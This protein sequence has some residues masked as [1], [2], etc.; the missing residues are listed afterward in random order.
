M[1]TADTQPG[2][3]E[4][5]MMRSEES[6]M[7]SEESM[8]RS[9]ES[10]MRSEESMMRSEESR[11]R[12]GG[13]VGSWESELTSRQRSLKF[14]LALKEEFVCPVCGGVVLNPQQNSC[15]HIYCYHCL[16]GLLESSSPSSPVC[17]VD[18]AVITPA[19]VFQDNCCRREISCL[20][21]YCTNFPACTSVVTLQHLQEHLSSCQYEQLQCT[22]P[23][24]RAA[25]QRRH[26][27]EHLTSTCPHRTEPCPHCQ[28]PIRLNLIQDHL[29]T[30]CLQVEVGCP[31]SCSQKVPRHKLAEHRESC[32]E[33]HVDCSYR[34]FG[35]LVQDKR[36]KV[37]LHEDTA[38]NHHMLLVLRSNTHLEQQV[39]VLQEEALLR[40]QEVQANSLLLTGLQKK[41]Q[42]LLQQSSGHEHVVSAAQRTLSRQEDILSTLQLD[43][44]QVSRGLCSGREE[45]EQ[46]RKSLDAV[47]QEVS[48]AEALKEHLETLE[49]K[50]KLHSSL[51]ELHAAQLHH[52]EQHLQELEATSYD[53]KLIW[54]IDDFR[55]RRE[56]EAKGQPPCLT[57]VPFLTGRCGYKMAARV[58]LNGDGEGRGT[59]LSLYVVLMQ[60]DFDALL[61]W[62]FRQTV[63]LSLLDQSGARNH[64]S[65][66][67]RPDPSSKSFQRPAAESVNVATGFSCF[68]PLARLE[69]PQNA[70]Y[71]DSDTLFV[72]V[73]V[74]MV[75]L[76]P[77]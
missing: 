70:S 44:Q 9:E 49:E 19:E 2:G 10:R 38:V 20:E 34:R 21:V 5:S 69:D 16:Q 28:Q 11:M 43:V 59:H 6:M 41:I 32:P 57:S 74:D 22:N 35:C 52:N 33:V 39:E 54:K 4:E 56:A 77:L 67:F 65:L 62:P 58:Y 26:L 73:W 31:H 47:I 63:S 25:P 68:I 12:S 15:G 53:G 8:M 14:V 36:E 30:S 42:P 48:A 17:P 3:S 64:R 18:G 55:K 13:P 51:S 71:V 24:C 7:R 66:S 29:Q 46:L 76:E 50:L 45:L 1:E 23:G 61:P 72:K 60:G 75:G 40:Q 27:Q 37:K